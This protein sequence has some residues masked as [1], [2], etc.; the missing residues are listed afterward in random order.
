MSQRKSE[1]ENGLSNLRQ[2]YEQFSKY[3]PEDAIDRTL[4]ALGTAGNKLERILSGGHSLYGWTSP[5][6]DDSD[7]LRRYLFG[8]NDAKTRD[9]KAA[10]LNKYIAARNKKIQ[11]WQEGID[12]NLK[13]RDKAYQNHQISD[14]FQF[15]EQQASGNVFDG[16]TWTFKQPGLQGY[17]SSSWIKLLPTYIGGPTSMFVKSGAARLVM[18]GTGF[19][20]AH[21]AAQGENF[22]ELR[23][24]YR[25]V[26][27]RNVKALEDG[28]KI[29]NTFIKEGK[30]R[31]NLSG[32]TE[33]VKK[34]VTD[35]F[36]DGRFRPTE[37]V[38]DLTEARANAAYGLNAL[39]DRDMV[40]V[41][42]DNVV[43]T[44]IMFGSFGRF[45]K[46]AKVAEPLAQYGSPIIGTSVA[47]LKRLPIFKE[48]AKKID[49]TASLLLSTPREIFGK[50][51]SKVTKGKLS[52]RLGKWATKSKHPLRKADGHTLWENTLKTLGYATKSAISE[53]IEEGKQYIHGHEY[54]EGKLADVNVSFGWGIDTEKWYDDMMA[55]IKSA[56]VIA[57]MPF[58]LEKMHDAEL[59]EN[60]KGGMMGGLFMTGGTQVA[61]GAI[62]TYRQMKINKYMFNNIIAE[63]AARTDLYEKAKLYAQ[64]SMS[65]ESVSRMNEAFDQMIRISENNKDQ[66]WY[67]PKPIIEEQKS[68]FNSV[69]KMTRNSAILDRATTLGI[70]QGTEQFFDFVAQV[71]LQDQILSETS[72]NYL[73]AWQMYNNL[74][75]DIEDVY[76][77]NE[78]GDI[79]QNVSVGSIPYSGALLMH[80]DGS[81]EIKEEAVIRLNNK[82][83]QLA[84]LALKMK[85]LQDLIVQVNLAD[86]NST[87]TQNS[88]SSLSFL[89][90]RLQK[91]LKNTSSILTDE[92][93][94]EQFIK[95]LDTRLRE[96]P[97]SQ[98]ILDAYRKYALLSVDMDYG[99][100]MYSSLMGEKSRSRYDEAFSPTRITD[101]TLDFLY[102]IPDEKYTTFAVISKAYRDRVKGDKA[103]YDAMEEDY[104]N[105]LEQLEDYEQTK[106]QA[107]YIR[108]H[109]Q[110][111]DT[112]RTANEIKQAQSTSKSTKYIETTR[113]N[114]EV[115]IYDQILQIAKKIKDSGKS[116]V[117]VVKNAFSESGV[118]FDK[119][120]NSAVFESSRR[121]VKGEMSPEQFAL[122]FIDPEDRSKIKSSEPETKPS[123]EQPKMPVQEPAK[124]PEK[125]PQPQEPKQPKKVAPQQISLLQNRNLQLEMY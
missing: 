66:E 44:S 121:L 57:G 27:E 1:L 88:K 26:F 55:D 37:N 98:E 9:Q 67:I 118:T 15:W 21:S 73:S 45:A 32:D 106:L 74:M 46:L 77:L 49:D 83:R 101:S 125:S 103:L 31:L 19:V 123:T 95:T 30:E 87:F 12:I 97:N 25:P 3:V 7:N 84:Q 109:P 107:E 47:T 11:D 85:T 16:D 68:L 81:A 53:G 79:M 63:K 10:I 99:R 51:A 119:M 39:F 76:Y 22:M 43:N 41:D 117:K 56:Y 100:M 35:A 17:S 36:L 13:E 91:Y 104:V 38:Q 89:K 93:Q 102:D 42:I 115:P 48:V 64:K 62:D 72:P 65:D 86:D 70:Q 60:I 80:D 96:I 34:A 6:F 59:V 78:Q 111:A 69:Q 120:Y 29:F 18:A 114:Q 2:R 82:H 24:N 8:F 122:L 20:G 124:Q 105:R 71:A 5:L 52:E 94:R 75:G 116:A 110:E 90:R 23:E 113:K 61:T 92:K 108:N 40:A 4:L 58:G 33:D 54:Q 28:N 50:A 14:Y 112:E